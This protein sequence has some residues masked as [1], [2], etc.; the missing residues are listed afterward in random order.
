MLFY[1]LVHVMEYT[2]GVNNKLDDIYN[3]VPSFLNLEYEDKNFFKNYQKNF[4]NN[5]RP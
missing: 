1:T 4:K 2:F 5:R 3:G